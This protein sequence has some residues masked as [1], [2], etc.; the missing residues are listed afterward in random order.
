MAAG[1][2]GGGAWAGLAGGGAV[3][4]GTLDVAGLAGTDVLKP[5]SSHTY[6]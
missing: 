6:T 2:A 3:R 5:L 1:P 4:A